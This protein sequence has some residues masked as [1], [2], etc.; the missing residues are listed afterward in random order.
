MNARYTIDCDVLPGMSAAY[1]RVARGE[2]AFIEAHTS[3]AV[4]RLLSA[5]AQHGQRPEDVRWVVVTHAHLDHAGGASALM[6]LLPNATLV[7]HPSAAKNLID[8]TKL[9]AGATE[10]YGA[11]R[12]ARLYGNIDPIPKERVLTLAAEGGKAPEAGCADGTSFELGGA[13][14]R[15]H[16]TAG[17]AW[18]HFVVDDPAM[19]TV[20][21]GD[22]FGLVYP[23]LQRAGR[24]AIASTSPTGFDPG[25]ARKSLE[26]ILSL[27][28]ASACLT[29]YD[30][31]RD[32]RDVAAQIGAWIDRSE[33]WRD[34]AVARGL[35]YDDAKREIE[36]SVRAALEA[37]ASRRGL[38]LDRADWELLAIDVDL[39]A[40]GIAFAASR[41]LAD[42]AKAAKI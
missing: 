29:H 24:F 7:A 6:A 26:R 27:G 34:D 3:H 8:P 1:L 41:I 37:D 39:N 10:V 30:E 32:L 40:Q 9:V 2:C 18:H 33:A 12:F 16:H 17:H 35:S 22:A 28:E 31:V 5:L 11:E 25:E 20:F 4:P 15:V 14:L 13:T 21:T 38:A 19:E 23:R 36:A 42:R